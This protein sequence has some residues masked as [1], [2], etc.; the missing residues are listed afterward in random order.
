[1]FEKAILALLAAPLITVMW[2]GMIYLGVDAYV[3]TRERLES[4]R[5]KRK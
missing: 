1:M 5:K 4:R 3:S 2:G